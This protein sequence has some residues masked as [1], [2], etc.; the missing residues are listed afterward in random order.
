VWN[1]VAISSR[2][3][4]RDE[5]A[6]LSG[7]Y[8]PLLGLLQHAQVGTLFLELCTPRAGE[9]E[10]LK[11]LPDDRRIGIGVVNQKHE[12]IESEDEI[13]SRIRR[14]I[15]LFGKDRVLLTPDCGFA[16]FADNPVASA[17]IAEA[18]LRAITRANEGLQG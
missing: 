5:S 15:D 18:K 6:A 17:T 16:T 14:A 7:D 11:D 4:T 1:G 3:R 13:V 12:R 8:R 2:L 9:L 10:I